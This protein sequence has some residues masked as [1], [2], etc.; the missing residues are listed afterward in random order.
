MQIYKNGHDENAQVIGVFWG[1]Y[2]Y[3]LDIISG[4]NC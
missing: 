3:F 1:H 2:L 4:N